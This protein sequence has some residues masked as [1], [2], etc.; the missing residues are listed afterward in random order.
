MNYSLWGTKK[1]GSLTWTEQRSWKNCYCGYG[2][3][4]FGRESR[5][6]VIRCAL[7]TDMYTREG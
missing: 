5:M 2:H 7:K 4:K 1:I 3:V 6:I